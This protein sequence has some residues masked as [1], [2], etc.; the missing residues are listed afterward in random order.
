MNEYQ[1]KLKKKMDEYAHLIYRIAKDFPRH[2]LYGIV[3]QIRRAALSIILNYIEG[4]ARKKPLVRLNFLE[5]SYGSLKESKYLLS[6]SLVE[7]YLNKNDYDHG[8]KLA[9]EIGAMLWKDIEGLKKFIDS[10]KN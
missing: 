9:D 5:I 1:K 3:S 8:I 4:W 10:N 2:E 6:F 7:E